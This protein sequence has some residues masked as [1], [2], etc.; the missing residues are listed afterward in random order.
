M[1]LKRIDAQRKKEKLGFTRCCMSAKVKYEY[2]REKPQVTGQKKARH[3]AKIL[4]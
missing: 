3:T 1:Y 2:S 4:T